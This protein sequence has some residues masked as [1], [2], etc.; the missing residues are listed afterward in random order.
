MYTDNL[1]NIISS[2]LK[3]VKS[4]KFNGLL[5]TQITSSSINFI[6]GIWNKTVVLNINRTLLSEESVAGFRNWLST[7]LPIAYYQLAT[8]T[9]TLLN[10]TL[11]E[12]L[13]IIEKLLS[14]K[15]QTNI[16]QEND[17]LPFDMVATALKDLSSL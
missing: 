8:P 1:P 11:Q 16:S 13:N 6:G 2:S 17:D 7:N 9:Y 5:R 3:V 14:Y 15:G 12:E 4:D 10:D